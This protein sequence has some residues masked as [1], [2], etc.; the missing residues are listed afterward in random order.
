MLINAEESWAFRET[1]SMRVGRGQVLAV[2]EVLAG[3]DA[4]GVTR[5]SIPES[6]IKRQ[7]GLDLELK[8]G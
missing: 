6:R 5:F 2:R 1:A 3:S 7:N 4:A 8:L